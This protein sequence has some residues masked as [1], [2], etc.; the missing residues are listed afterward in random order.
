MKIKDKGFSLVEL[1]VV[2][3]IMAILAAALAPQLMKYVEKSRK[4]VDEQNCKAIERVMQ[5][6]ISDEKV[7]SEVSKG[8]DGNQFRFYI[9]M[10]D[11]GSTLLI[12][13]LLDN[14]ITSNEIRS[15]IGKIENPKQ[16]GTNSYEIIIKGIKKT[17]NGSVVFTVDNVSVSTSSRKFDSN[18]ETNYNY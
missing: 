18:C 9:R 5:I 13:G 8:R 1:I 11:D 6:A 16:V 3:A 12:D 7:W 2:I 17:E 14:Y 10:S 15:L 4:T